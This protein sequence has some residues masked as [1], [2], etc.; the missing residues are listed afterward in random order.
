[1]KE[2]VKIK[3]F[4]GMMMQLQKDNILQ[5][6]QNMESDQIPYIIYVI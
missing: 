3:N 6:N 2:F 5:L 1:M 4:C